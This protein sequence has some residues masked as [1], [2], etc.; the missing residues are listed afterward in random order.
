MIRR[1]RGEAGRA[2]RRR[3]AGS[4]PPIVG[5]NATPRRHVASSAEVR[6][7]SNPGWRG[8]YVIGAIVMVAVAIVAAIGHMDIHAKTRWGDEFELKHSSSVPG[9]P[10][11]A[12]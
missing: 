9:W 2:Q 10:G 4:R 3:L 7:S 1:R 5:E 6:S 8:P 11:D 12:R